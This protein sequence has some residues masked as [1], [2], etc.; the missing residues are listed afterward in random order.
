MLSNRAP[1][2]LPSMPDDMSSWCAMP[3]PFPVTISQILDMSREAPCRGKVVALGVH[4]KNFHKY[5]IL[6][7]A[8]ELHCRGKVGVALP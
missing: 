7:M 1:H 8:R 2:D 4:S 5:Q 3:L 6:E